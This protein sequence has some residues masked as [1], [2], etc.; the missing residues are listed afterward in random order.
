MKKIKFLRLCFNN[1][2]TDTEIP[3][4][5]AAIA[6][7]AGSNNPLFH[8]HLSDQL[9]YRYPLIQFKTIGRQPSI[10][11]LEQG[12]EALQNLLSQKDWT[13]HIGQTVHQLEVERIDMHMVTLHVWDRLLTYRLNNWIAL[14]QTNYKKHLENLSLAS[15]VKDL[16]KILTAHILSFA[17]GVKWNIEKPIEVTI[18]RIHAERWIKFKNVKLL[19]FDVSF[20]ANVSLPEYAGLGKAPSIG[21]G[22]IRRIRLQHLTGKSLNKAI[23]RHE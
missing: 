6:K 7:L 3:A 22:T 23:A 8:H 14:N 15:R 19:A 21:Y 13:I 2:I 1:P 17:E 20:S 9:L 12:T 10:I 18:Q 4:F 16:E 11:A 5:R